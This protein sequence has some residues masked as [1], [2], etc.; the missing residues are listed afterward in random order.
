MPEFSICMA[1]L[2]CSA[3]LI[4]VGLSS[5]LPVARVV[6]DISVFKH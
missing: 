2:K 6:M 1:M 5:G 3:T 4:P